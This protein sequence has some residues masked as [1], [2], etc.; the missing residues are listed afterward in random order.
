VLSLNTAIAQQNLK[1]TVILYNVVPLRV[2]LNQDG[3]IQTIYGEDTKFLKGYT[4]VR[5]QTSGESS[6]YAQNKGYY[7]VSKENFN[8]N[9]S[10]NSAVLSENA[11]KDLDKSADMAFFGDHRIMVSSYKPTDDPKS[12]TL[13]KNRMNACLMYLELKGVAK[14]KIIINE[15]G[16]QSS[17][18]FIKLTFVK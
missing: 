7:V 11:V 3:T 17:E 1:N 18:E 10:T 15:E 16:L 4:I 5:P 8:L 2:D 14:D 13:F 12:K 9:F 6:E